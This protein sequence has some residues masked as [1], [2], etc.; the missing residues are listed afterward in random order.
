MWSDKRDDIMKLLED[1]AERFP[2]ICP[3]CGKKT[4]HLFFY[5]HHEEKAGGAWVW[6]SECQE[7]SHSLFH[8]PEWWRNMDTISLKD[9]HHCPDNL[10]DMH[11][12]ID[13][14]VNKLLDDKENDVHHNTIDFS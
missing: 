11:E 3:C 2:R 14:W 4:G 5:R 12:S 8:I 13:E 9:L 1:S 6:C 7:Y 10:D